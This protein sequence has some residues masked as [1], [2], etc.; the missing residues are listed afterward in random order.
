MWEAVGLCVPMLPRQ[1]DG[2]STREA[3]EC[4]G[5]GLWTLQAKSL[6]RTSQFRPL[7]DINP[8]PDKRARGSAFTARVLSHLWKAQLSVPQPAAPFYG[9]SA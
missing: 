3:L 2:L 1:V 8:I 6:A 7:A 9:R 4:P 5:E